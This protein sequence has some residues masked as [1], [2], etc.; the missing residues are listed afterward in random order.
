MRFRLR[1]FSTE[2]LQEWV[3]LSTTEGLVRLRVGSKTDCKGG[4]YRRGV[5]HHDVYFL[6]EGTVDRVQETSLWDRPEV[7]RTLRPRVGPSRSS[8]TAR[9]SGWGRSR[10]RVTRPY[11][12]LPSLRDTKHSKRDKPTSP[13][14]F[15]YSPYSFSFF[16]PTAWE[17]LKR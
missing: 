15:H 16:Y 13:Y 6:S 4:L 12:Y 8:R 11:Q 17:V 7:P 9:V 1:T 3:G 14:S 5:F 2:R 10:P